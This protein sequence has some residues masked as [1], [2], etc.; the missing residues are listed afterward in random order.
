MATLTSHAGTHE[1]VLPAVCTEYKPQQFWDTHQTGEASLQ[2]DLSC[3]QRLRRRLRA[4][5]ASWLFRLQLK[6][7]L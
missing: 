7:L 1:Y 6:Q 4:A 3:M 2:T 5:N